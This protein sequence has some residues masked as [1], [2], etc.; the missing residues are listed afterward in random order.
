M[1]KLKD[2]LNKLKKD[3]SL[4]ERN[5]YVMRSFNFFFFIN[6]FYIIIFFFYL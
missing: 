4:G 2:D 1:N 5:M 3:K 6:I